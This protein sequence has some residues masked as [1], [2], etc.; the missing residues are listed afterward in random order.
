RGPRGYRRSSESGGFG[1]VRRVGRGLGE[2]LQFG[3]VVGGVEGGTGEPEAF[4]LDEFGP[5]PAEG[6]YSHA[7]WGGVV[8]PEH[9]EAAVVRDERLPVV[10]HLPDAFADGFSGAWRSIDTR[11][12]G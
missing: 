4:M 11:G 12:D 8:G 10:E 1:G 6:E 9:R 3:E 5:G 7:R 2:F